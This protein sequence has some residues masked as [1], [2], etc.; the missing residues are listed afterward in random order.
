[1]DR[2][3]RR[4]VKVAQLN[5]DRARGVAAELRTKAV[6]EGIQVM[7]IQEPYVN[8]NGMVEGYGLGSRVVTGEGEGERPWAAVVGLDPNIGMMRVGA[9]CSSHCVVV[10][11]LPEGCGSFYL[12]SL[13]CQFGHDLGRYLEELRKVANALR[14]RRLVVSMDANA[15]NVWWGGVVT[16]ER[17][18]ELEAFMME[19]GWS[20]LNDSTQPGTFRGPTSKEESYIDVTVVGGGLEVGS[21][22]WKVEAEWTSSSHRVITFEI[23]GCGIGGRRRV[24]WKYNLKAADWDKFRKEL[25][26]RRG[27]IE[28]FPLNGKT[29]VIKY[30]KVVE[31]WVKEAADKVV[32]KGAGGAKRVVWW[33]PKL[34]EMRKA[35]LKLRRKM[36]GERD[37]SRREELAAM[38]R[39]ARSQYRKEIHRAKEDSWKEFVEEQ[40][41]V[42]GSPWNIVYKL[43]SKKV[44]PREVMEA[45]RGPQG[46]SYE[47]E[48]AAKRLL[49]A[50]VPDDDG[51][52]DDDHRRVRE[53]VD[54]M[55]LPRGP[56]VVV[57]EREVMDAVGKMARGKAAGRD[58]IPSEL[59]IE[60]GC[61]LVRVLTRLF[62]GCFDQG[63]FPNRWKFGRIKA[64]LKGEDKDKREAKSYRPICLLPVLGKV[65]ERV[66]VAKLDE[67][68]QVKV[69][70]CQYGFM[71][72][73][74]TEDAMEAVRTIVQERREKYVIGAFLD[75][76]A[77]FDGVWWPGLRKKLQQLGVRGRC[78]ALLEDYLRGRRV[79]MV[80]GDRRVGKRVTK[81]CPQ[82]SVLGPQL[83]K[84]VFHGLV[85]DLEGEELRVV[86]FADDGLVIMWGNSRRQLEERAEAAMRKVQEWCRK[87]KMRL[88]AEKT[89]IMML[90]GKFDVERG[91]KV[92]MDGVRLRLAVRV[93]YLGVVWEQGW[94]IGKHVEEVVEKAKRR[95]KA[96]LRYTRV[97]WSKIL[98]ER[99]VQIYKAVFVPIIGYAAGVW[100]ESVVP[101]RAARTVLSGQRLALVWMSRAY[102]TVS[103]DAIGVVG[104]LPPMDLELE[105]LVIARKL[106]KCGR[107]EWRGRELRGRR[108]RSDLRRVVMEEWQRRWNDSEKGRWT[109]RWM[110]SVDE[111]LDRSWIYPDYYVTQMLTGHGD[112]R[113]K[114]RSFGLSEEGSCRCGE[115]E[116]TA[117]H[118]LRTCKRFGEERRRM[119]EEIR[120]LLGAVV[121]SM[122]E[123][124]GKEE[125]YKCFREY[126]EKVMK[127]KEDEERREALG[128]R[129]PA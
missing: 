22:Q 49:T 2:R 107:A 72:G 48:E 39:A 87:S 47:W 103:G 5:A 37:Q 45:V 63:V 7:A 118:V 20:V 43:A 54:G 29:S 74:S 106:K 81:G 77:A 128:R 59:I 92:M 6:T 13:Y 119:E 76:S 101:S 83:W 51:V 114:L 73:R 57:S 123:V 70:D 14:G 122:E 32:R 35:S 68:F 88:S 55:K 89:Q 108:C 69:R 33:S 78:Y 124:L 31:D 12:V 113:E 27:E 25:G 19:Q 60:G 3:K 18:E 91:P 102:R 95:L 127:I 42:E 120:R 15:K 104:G 93:R 65:L 125:T 82:G 40:F 85:Q 23:G 53:E 105:K 121:W 66:L 96:L 67:V 80:E 98:W 8:R 26:K 17:G 94:R 1:M 36:Q 41:G 52:E 24:E 16:D 75:I 79:E 38:Y 62:Q 90:K 112:F 50:L 116:E 86:V 110:P 71:K 11:V 44:K 64:L 21:G 97:T 129:E 10:E 126:V 58:G 34:E 4:T 84:V 28:N 56:R 99:I 109:Y 115:G 9:L 61:E 30:V 100:W 111:R 46:E 117:D